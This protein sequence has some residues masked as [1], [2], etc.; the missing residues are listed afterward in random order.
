MDDSSSTLLSDAS[1]E[2]VKGG[3]QIPRWIKVSAIAAASAL[4]GGLA[5]AWMYRKTVQRLHNAVETAENP[6]FRM[7]GRGGYED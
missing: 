6:K 7:P 5:A 2:E 1:T 3:K 4:A